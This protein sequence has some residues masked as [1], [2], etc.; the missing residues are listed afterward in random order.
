MSQFDIK[1]IAQLAQLE[2]KPEE[3]ESLTKQVNNTIHWVEKLSEVNTNEVLENNN[4]NK[5]FMQEDKAI[6]TNIE[7]I[8]NEENS[9][10]NYFFVPK[11]IE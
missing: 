8:L 4:Q 6:K 11:V 10:Y 9:K 5:L 1:K 3:I 2:I 7:D